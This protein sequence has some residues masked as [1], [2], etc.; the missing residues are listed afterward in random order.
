MLLRILQPK[1]H[2]DAPQTKFVTVVSLCLPVTIFVATQ[3]FAGNS[4][5]FGP[6]QLVG[7]KACQSS[8]RA[9]FRLQRG[10][11]GPK[12]GFE[13]W[14]QAHTYHEGRQVGVVALL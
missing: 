12:L 8:S 7:H 13:G 2:V 11:A 1:P 10:H 3:T 6:D 5:F 14:L 4:E 9:G